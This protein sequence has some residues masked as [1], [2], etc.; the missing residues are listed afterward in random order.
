M[1]K[2]CSP[3]EQDL[4]PALSGQQ[5]GTSRTFLYTMQRNQMVMTLTSAS[6]S[7]VRKSFIKRNTPLCMDPTEKE[8]QLEEV[9]LKQEECL[10]K[11]L[12]AQEQEEQM[13]EEMK[14][15]T[16]QK[17]AQLDEKAKEE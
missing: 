9:R 2:S 8:Q 1:R 10:P 13:Q 6:C 11:V 4:F 5:D 12:Q 17:F 15:Q 16:D 7:S 14:K 3:P